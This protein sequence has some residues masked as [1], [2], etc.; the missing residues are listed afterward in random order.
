MAPPTVSCRAKVTCSGRA[1]PPDVIGPG[2]FAIDGPAPV[3]V[4]SAAI[5]SGMGSYR[6]TPGS[7]DGNPGHNVE[8]IVPP[9]DRTRTYSSVLTIT[10]A[11]GP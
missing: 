3:T 7:L 10:I 6:F 11:T 8:V 1:A 5:N 2:P 4:A 9:S